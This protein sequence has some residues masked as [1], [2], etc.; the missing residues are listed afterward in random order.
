V[1]DKIYHDSKHALVRLTPT[2]IYKHI[3]TSPVALCI[4][5][6]S[7]NRRG[8]GVGILHYEERGELKMNRLYLA[9]HWRAAPPSRERKEGGEG[10]LGSAGG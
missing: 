5:E 6:G 8:K 3:Y 10:E 2:T 9:R 1:V 4:T 7:S